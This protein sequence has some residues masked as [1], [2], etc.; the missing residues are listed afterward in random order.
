MDLATGYFFVHNSEDGLQVNGP[1]SAE[2]ALDHIKGVTGQ[3]IVPEYQARFVAGIPDEAS[4]PEDYCV[5]RGTI[6]VPDKVEVV[7]EYTL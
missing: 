6:V 5:I 4:P 7:T 3:D 1:L 2:A